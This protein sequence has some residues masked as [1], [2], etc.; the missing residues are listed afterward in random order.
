M[1]L[2][3]LLKENIEILRRMKNEEWDTDKFIEEL[4]NSQQVKE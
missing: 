3:E 4:K 1:T 2:D